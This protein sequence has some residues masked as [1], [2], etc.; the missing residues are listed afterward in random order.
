MV[1]ADWSKNPRKRWEARV[2]PTRSGGRVSAPTP[3]LDAAVWVAELVG[4]ARRGRAVLL[5]VDFGLGVPVAFARACRPRVRSFLELVDGA[6]EPLFAEERAM[7]RVCPERPFFRPAG[8]PFELDAL[9]A[10]LGAPS[11]RA[12][13]RRC[14]RA[15][16]G[17]PRDACPVFVPRPTQDVTGAT[18][19]GWLEVLRPARAAGAKV[20][21]F[22]G[23]LDALVRPGALVLAE[24]YPAEV[25]AWLGLPRGKRRP[26]SRAAMARALASALR[27][28]G[29]EADAALAQDLADCV[30]DHPGAP[31]EDRLDAVIGAVGLARVRAGAIDARAPRDR[32]VRAIEGWVLGRPDD[33]LSTGSGRSRRRTS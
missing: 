10:R 4:V 2:I 30:P 31:G 17:R 14:E 6:P 1:F 21:P 7:E 26:E 20:W 33:G 22:D 28:A 16:P 11:W 8:Q 23:E 24:T 3:I 12:L 18:R 27:E 13:L 29:L 25:G 5:G 15:H 19:T 9:A 32:E